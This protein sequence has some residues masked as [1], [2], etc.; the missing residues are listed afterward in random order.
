MKYL[1]PQEILYIHNRIIEEVGGSHGAKDILVLKKLIKYT[2]NAE[3][4]PDKLSKA[5]ALFFGIAKKKPFSDKNLET[6][7]IALEIF[8]SLNKYTLDI[9]KPAFQRFVNQ[10][11]SEA[12]VEDIRR[13]LIENS[14]PA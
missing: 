4:F 13:F 7:V 9:S 8:L 5:A 2:H 11:L 14:R 12:K 10:E 3:I 1:S 6:G